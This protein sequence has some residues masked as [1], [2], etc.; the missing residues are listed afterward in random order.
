MIIL[1]FN[2]NSDKLEKLCI[3]LW[4]ECLNKVK[5]TIEKSRLKKEDIDEIILVYNQQE[6]QKYKK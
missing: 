3:D 1:Q 6:Y 5:E 2:I 4:K